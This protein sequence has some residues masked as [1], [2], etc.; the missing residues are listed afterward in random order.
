MKRIWKGAFVIIS[1]NSLFQSFPE[2][3][4]QYHQKNQTIFRVARLCNY[5]LR[6]SVLLN[7]DTVK[8]DTIFPTFLKFQANHEE[9]ISYKRR[10][11]VP[12]K[13]PATLSQWHSIICSKTEVLN[14]R[15]PNVLVKIEPFLFLVHMN[16]LPLESTYSAIIQPS[17]LKGR[18]RSKESFICWWWWTL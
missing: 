4:R 17:R 16:T 14:V 7:C 8:F 11:Y 6:S 12:S 1:L 10:Q 3:I 13:L 15:T 9:T 5:G 18:R 2:I